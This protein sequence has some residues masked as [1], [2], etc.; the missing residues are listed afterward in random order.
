[1]HHNVTFLPV[2]VRTEQDGDESV[3]KRRMTKGGIV[4]SETYTRYIG[5][6]EI[7][8]LQTFYRQSP[9]LL[10]LAKKFYEKVTAKMLYTHHI[11]P[12]LLVRPDLAFV[13]SMPRFCLWSNSI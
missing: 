11:Q 8:S 4:D 10:E 6:R 9:T 2:G 13:V 7:K 1:V 5:N 3:S 12:R